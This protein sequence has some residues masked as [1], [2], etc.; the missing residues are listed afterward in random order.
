MLIN[1]SEVS[2]YTD[3]E[4]FRPFERYK[5]FSQKAT[6]VELQHKIDKR[7]DDRNYVPTHCL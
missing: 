2:F 1:S 5:A 6:A 7:F 3:L 4:S